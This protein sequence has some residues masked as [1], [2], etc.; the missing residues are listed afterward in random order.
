M[1]YTK[2]LL[3]Y[4]NDV[5]MANPD[6]RQYKK[7]KIKKNPMSEED[8]KKNPEK[9]AMQDPYVQPTQSG[10]EKPTKPK[11]NPGKE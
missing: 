1:V 4:F 9:G 3:I 10:G 2:N 5:I 8:V 6:N 7:D 11:G